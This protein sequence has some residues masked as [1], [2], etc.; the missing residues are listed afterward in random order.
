MTASP[1]LSSIERSRAAAELEE[2]GMSYCL[3]SDAM[4]EEILERQKQRPLP[5]QG[6]LENYTGCLKGCGSCIERLRGYFALAEA[7][8]ALKTSSG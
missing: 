7:F 1:S 5:F 8:I 3:C 6:V 2:Q 4:F